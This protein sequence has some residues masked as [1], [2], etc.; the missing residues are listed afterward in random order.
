MNLILSSITTA[1]VNLVVF[2]IIPFIWWFIRHRKNVGFFKWIG[3]YKPQLKSKWWVLVVFG[4]I[5]YFS[6]SFDFTQLLDKS[7]LEYIENNSSVSANA[8]AGIGAMAILP[9]LIENFIANGLSEE[10]LFR[11]FLNKRLCNKFGKVQGI[12]IQAVLF[13]LMHN[14]M[15]ILAGLDVGLWYHTLVFVFTGTGA[16]LLGWLNE[17][18]FNGSIIPSILLHGAG[19]FISSMLVAFV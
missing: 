11:G 7:T 10:I 17:K 13:G 5:Y 1:I 2:S 18:I 8:F 14:M 6:Y 19:N 16:L 3:I 12:I 4:V 15:Y 9:A